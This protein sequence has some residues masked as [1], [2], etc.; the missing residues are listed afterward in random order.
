MPF[1]FAL[2]LFS[3]SATVAHDIQDHSTF[4]PFAEH[5]SLSLLLVVVRDIP[6]R[7]AFFPFDE[8]H[9][10]S[11]LLA[12]VQVPLMLMLMCECIEWKELPFHLVFQ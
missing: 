11:L 1:I 2:V 12:V 9:S 8:H 7:S 10:L 3:D 6:D 4:F 5:Y